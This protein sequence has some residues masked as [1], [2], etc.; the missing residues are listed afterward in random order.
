MIDY[1]ERIELKTWSEFKELAENSRLEWIFRGQSN[2]EWDLET[3]LQRSNIIEN[4]PHFEDEILDDFKRGLKFYLD[5]EELPESTLEYFSMLQHF[6]APSRLL[7]FTKSPYIAAY[8]AFE[9]AS[10]QIEK[11]AIWVV[12]KIN[13]FQRSIYYFENKIDFTK[14][15]N[16][17]YTFDD[18][19]F[20]DA[21]EKSKRE[22]FNCIFPTEPINQ[23]KRYHFQQS[24][25]LTQGNPYEQFGKQLDFI[26][27][28]ILKKTFMKV[29]IPS[30]E[31]K[32]AIRDLI[33]MN[34]NRATLFPGLDGF[35]KSLLLKFGNLSTFEETFKFL[36]YAKKRKMA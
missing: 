26:N 15:K 34:V 12:N 3:T 19:V 30:T 7:D 21:F 36:E 8:F 25:F 10:E 1:F 11:V 9:Q 23:N 33:K 5:K 2:S 16:T 28:D 6:G 20:E 35:A 27:K 24:I 32:N 29:T 14:N 18:L 31:K 22:N 17:N 13:L 4:F